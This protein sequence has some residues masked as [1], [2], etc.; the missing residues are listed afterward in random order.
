M[1]YKCD[2]N[3]ISF[4]SNIGFSCPKC[5]PVRVSLLRISESLSH[6]ASTREW[7]VDSGA[8]VHCV[9]DS[10]MLTSVYTDHPPVNIKVADNRVITAAAVGTC[11]TTMRNSQGQLHTIT[12][13]NVVYHPHFAHNLLSVRRLLRDNRLTT[14]FKED[15]YFRC[16]ATKHRFPFSCPH[17]QYVAESAFSA[18]VDPS[19]LHSR[20]GH[21]SSRRLRKLAERSV[22]FPK[23]S[24]TDM[25]HDPTNCD[26]CQ[27][28]GQRKKPFPKN[29]RNPYS[30]FGE[31][32]SSDLCGPFPKSVGGYKYLLNIVD[33]CTNYL[34]VFHLRSKSSEVVKAHLEQ[35]L[36][37]NRDKLPSPESGRPIR[38][39]TDNGGE[40]ISDDLQEFCNEFAVKRSFSV[41]YAPPQNAHAE[42]MWGILLRTMRTI[43]AES[44]VHESFWTFA[45]DHA[46]M[47]HNSL[48][49]IRLAGEISPYQAKFGVPPDVSKVKVWGCT[50]WFY[51][52]EKD[53]ISKISPRALPAIHLGIDPQ[54]NGYV[55]YVPH[56][57]R[58]TSAY[59]LTFQERK[60]LAFTPEGVVNL[61]RKIKPLREVERSYEEP[62]DHGRDESPHDQ[63]DGDNNGVPDTVSPPCHNP[64]CTL[65]AH[66]H[67]TPHSFERL[68]TRDRGRSPRLAQRSNNEGDDDD[69]DDRPHHVSFSELIMLT[70]DVSKQEV[71]VHPEDIL[72]DAGTPKD[73]RSA[74]SSRHWP[75]WQESMNKEISDLLKHDTWE[76]VPRDKVPKTHRVTKSRWVY[77]VKLNRDGSIERFK[78]RFVVCGYSQVKGVDYTHSFSATM[79]ATSFR[80]LLALAAGENLK[81]E[82][83]DVTSAFT[84]AEI[85]SEIYVD[86]PQGYP[87]Y[88]GFVLKL[89]KSLYGTKQASRMWQ[90][91]LRTKLLGLGFTNST[92]DPCLFSK[93]DADGS[94]MLIGCY[95][96]DL[97]LAHNGKKLKWFIDEFTGPGGFRARHEG[98]LTWFLGVGVDQAPDFSVTIDQ[99]QYID[100][101]V[102][103]FVPAREA[104]LIKHSMPCNPIAF[105]QLS[106]AQ[107]D[108]DRDKMTRL[109]YLQLI[110]SLLYLSTM[111]RPDIAYHMSVLCS[112]MHDPSPAAYYAA[113]DLLLYVS[114]TRHITFTFPGS[115]AAPQGLESKWHS[116]VSSNG[117]LVAYSDSSWR[118]P[119]KFGFNSF[120]YVVYLYGAPISFA[121]KRL[122]VVALSS[123]EAEYAAASYAAR[124]IEFV[125]HVLTDLGFRISGPTVLAVDNQAAI[126][127]AENMGVASKTKHFVDAI[128][129][130]RHLVDH[131]AIQLS[132]VRT[133]FQRAD[134]FTKPLGKG[135]FAVWQRCLVHVPM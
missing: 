47:L 122:K 101:M 23:H 94:I 65:P 25:E 135:P 95:V 129:Y 15:C 50:C 26:A 36:D 99:H 124:E 62:R 31:K 127:I 87:E 59:H 98:P 21:C 66:S 107:S 28:G 67:G 45:A 71:A 54:R 17:G 14:H 13:H 19:I 109:P 104:S 53:R 24:A 7:I 10:S 89:K 105:Q 37:N 114:H 88:N 121:S 30:Y 41:P 18:S 118:R 91:K 92:H 70:D 4:F 81:L 128:H 116:N 131:R 6:V 5:R 51:L 76:L 90:L 75:R 40:F 56:L 44:G 100:K 48:P 119:D 69:D 126:K 63:A 72:S 73:F 123:A 86:P 20:F 80:L 132:F 52:P 102:E 115:K 9:G 113:I 79:R 3:R 82:H 43:L 34:E 110:G 58:I 96:D 2:R 97:V 133:D 68:P 33:A 130:L 93:R 106:T 85:D 64:N 29:V 134:G 117:G 27:A 16:R 49:S 42:R 22:N 12:L 103:R 111:T 78:S 39:H 74:K 83:F 35:F 77:K 32:L 8:T 55:I 38:W 11:E 112:F 120:G 125:R 57:H 84:Q 1:I 46:C 60:F 108:A 61:P